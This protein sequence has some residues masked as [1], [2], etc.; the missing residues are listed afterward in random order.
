MFA[1]YFWR[2]L[3][4]ASALAFCGIAVAE[5]READAQWGLAA[6]NAQKAHEAGYSGKGVRV[7][8]I[9]SG[10]DIGHSE[11]T[12]RVSPDSLDIDASFAAGRAMPVRGD[13]EGHGTFIAGVMA[14]GRDGKGMHGIA[15]DALLVPVSDGA[16]RVPLA[17]LI[18]YGHPH[19][20]EQGVEFVNASVGVD[21]SEVPA[22][23][24]QA[25]IEGYLP[26]AVPALREAARR[27]V[28]TVWAAG[29]DAGENA[30]LQA[31]LPHYYPELEETT[32]SVVA[33]DRAGF[34]AS[35]SNRCGVAAAW[36]LAAPG[37]EGDIGDPEGILSVAAGGGYMTASGT[38]VSAPHVTGA[39][40][41]ARQ[42]FPQAD[43]RD[44]RRLLLQTAVD[45]GAPGVDATFGWGRLDLGNVV[46]VISPSGRSIFAG[47]AWSRHMAMGQVAGA[48]FLAALVRPAASRRVWM[49]GSLET[50]GIDASPGLPGTRGRSRMLVAGV[51]LI[52]RDDLT[53]GIGLGYT[54]IRT[55]ERGTANEATA[56]GFHGFGYGRWDGEGW[57]AKASAGLSHFRQKH[58]RRTIPGLAG[59]A[60]ALQNPEAR[61]RNAV[62]GAFADLEAG[63][64][65]DLGRVDVSMFARLSS[66]Y[67][68]F[69]SASESG[70]ESLGYDL[71]SGSVSTAGVGPGIR[72]SN[73]FSLGGWQVEPELEISYARLVGSDGFT[74]GTRLLGREMEARTAPLGRDLFGIGAKVGLRVPETGLT[75]FLGYSGSFREASERHQA[76]LGLSFS[77]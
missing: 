21:E 16:G 61:S 73:R 2:A 69:G 3:A 15:Y 46:D 11:F 30:E 24:G 9:D 57:Y 23:A 17:A 7:G 63:R 10:L 41:V 60:L 22:G 6:V 37:G 34:L 26:D 32:L 38:S 68:H 13:E 70:L 50:A 45:L 66:A 39:L 76:R 64:K 58:A 19:L 20:A 29:N 56:G 55:R 47:A 27:G 77:F 59:T 54:G 28:V 43:T 18:R 72:V 71:R 14:A 52:E 53:A 49:T 62:W 65:V 8:F 1:L 35:Y 67:Q 44:L 42:I 33:L 36:C 51:D 31:R 48:P 74:V 4:G 25:F 75:A 12:G 40:A 5:E